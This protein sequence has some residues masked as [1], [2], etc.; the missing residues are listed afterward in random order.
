MP[1]D[2]RMCRPT[3]AT[4]LGRPNKLPLTPIFFPRHLSCTQSE[5]MVYNKRCLIF[6]VGNDDAGPQ[7]TCN[8]R[9]DIEERCAI[10]AFGRSTARSASV[11]VQ[12][13]LEPL[14]VTT[15]ATIRMYT[16]SRSYHLTGANPSRTSTS[17]TRV[18]PRVGENP[19]STAV[20]V[21]PVVTYH[22][23]MVYVRGCMLFE[24]GFTKDQRD[25]S[26]RRR[27][28]TPC[29]TIFSHRLSQQGMG[30]LLS[31]SCQKCATLWKEGKLPEITVCEKYSKQNVFFYT[32]K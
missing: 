23:C 10:H 24:S 12:T 1:S 15:Q 30:H 11:F 27:R 6:L 28:S 22:E 25:K 14:C 29:I 20:Y 9:T 4:P 2:S 26:D 5:E 19:H 13:P 31:S 3:N 21:R 16:S 17:R 18:R 32:R 8:P 7:K